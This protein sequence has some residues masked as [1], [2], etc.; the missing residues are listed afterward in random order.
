[1]KN[2][3]KNYL[4]LLGKAVLIK[5]PIN[6]IDRLFSYNIISYLSIAKF[7]NIIHRF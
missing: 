7:L 3:D 2:D 4:N 6:L 5:I 1:M